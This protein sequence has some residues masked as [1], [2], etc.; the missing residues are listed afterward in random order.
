M[1]IFVETDQPAR[2]FGDVQVI[3]GQWPR[4]A[5]V[6]A[7]HRERSGDTYTVLWPSGQTDFGIE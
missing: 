3:L 2:A 1:N 6:R 7:A 5:E 4:W